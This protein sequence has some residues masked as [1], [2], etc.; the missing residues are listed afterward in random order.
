MQLSGVTFYIF[1]GLVAALVLAWLAFFL[2]NKDAALKR[3][4]WRYGVPIIAAV[5]GLLIVA[6]SNSPTMVFFT[7][8]AVGFV[9]FV[10]LRQVK[11]CDACG[12][13]LYNTNWSRKMETC[14]RCDAQLTR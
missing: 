8:L 12:A 7:M 3:R 6:P 4:V 5:F 9:V 11:F 10:N 1:V 2:V 13:T 14:P